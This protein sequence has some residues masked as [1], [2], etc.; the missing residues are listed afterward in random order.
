MRKY[1]VIAPISLTIA[2][3]INGCNDTKISQCQRLIKVVNQGTSLIDNNKGT[4]V[5]TSLQLSNDLQ[6]V[7]KAIQELRL[8]D[9][10]LQK[11]QSSFAKVFDHLSRAI[12]QAAS[13]LGTAKTAEAS[14]AGRVKIQKARTNIDS[15]L[16]AAAKT[17]GRESDIFGQ[18]LNEYCSQSQ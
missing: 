13:A 8:T 17:A 14:T 5:T 2:L 6:N 11:F 18:Q 7:T 15:T 12:A 4:Q 16:T 9:P 1:T 10:K 3:L